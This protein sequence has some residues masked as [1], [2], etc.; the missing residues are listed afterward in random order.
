VI[1]S[2]RAQRAPKQVEAKNLSSIIESFKKEKTAFN[3]RFLE[4]KRRLDNFNEGKKT[5]HGR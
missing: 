5:S 3:E 2:P 1:A 4:L